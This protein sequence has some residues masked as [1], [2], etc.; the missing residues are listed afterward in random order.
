MYKKIKK[1]ELI[2]QNSAF[3]TTVMEKSLQDKTSLGS[4]HF[5]NVRA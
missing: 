1:Q 3:P 5:S 4:S 2:S